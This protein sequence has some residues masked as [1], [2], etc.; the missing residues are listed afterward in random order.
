MKNIQKKNS[1]KPPRKNDPSCKN[2]FPSEP[3]FKNKARQIMEGLTSNY[4]VGFYTTITANYLN[5]AL[6]KGEAVASR[7]ARAIVISFRF[8]ETVNIEGIA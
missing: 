8:R 5:T 7:D 1:S 3:Y 6:D 2:Y 4:P